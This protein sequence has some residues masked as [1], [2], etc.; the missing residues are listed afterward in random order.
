VSW[1]V[2]S[3]EKVTATVVRAPNGAR[4]RPA[5]QRGAR[6]H[7]G[8]PDGGRPTGNYMCK[9]LRMRRGEEDGD[10]NRTRS[11]ARATLLGLETD[12]KGTAGK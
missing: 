11:D 8:R 7:P 6:Q 2:S 3:Y 4:Q 12:C 10:N 5:T 1:T 9:A